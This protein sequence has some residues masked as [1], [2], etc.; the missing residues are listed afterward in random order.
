MTRARL[1]QTREA[2]P[3]ADDQEDGD[4]DGQCRGAVADGTK[5]HGDRLGRVF[6]F[7]FRH[8][9]ILA[10]KGKCQNLWS[11]GYWFVW[12]RLNLAFY[13]EFVILQKNEPRE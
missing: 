8:A 5:R 7:Q 4:G 13:N 10:R 11:I 1:S 3:Q 9:E 12:R 2:L 6:M